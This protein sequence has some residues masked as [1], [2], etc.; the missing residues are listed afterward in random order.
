MPHISFS[1][2]MEDLSVTGL[3]VTMSVTITGVE[4]SERSRSVAVLSIKPAS[5]PSF[6]ATVMLTIDNGERKIH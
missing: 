6:N 4:H 2:Q 5:I 3:V 1:K